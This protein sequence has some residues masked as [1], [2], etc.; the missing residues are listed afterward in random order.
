[1]SAFALLHG[2]AG[3]LAAV[4]KGHGGRVAQAQESLA[5]G[6]HPGGHSWPSRGSGCWGAPGEEV[7]SQS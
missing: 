4:P 3:F 7:T 1:M 6:T 5:A 2:N